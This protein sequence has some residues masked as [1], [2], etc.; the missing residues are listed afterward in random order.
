M[1]IN[2]RPEIDGLR[3]IAVF[4]VILYHANFILFDQDLFQG[5]FLG[6]DIFFVISGYLITSIILKEVTNSNQFSFK[7]FYVRRIRRI[8]PALFFVMFISLIAGYFLLLPNSFVDFGKSIASAVFFSSNIYFHFTRNGY[9]LDETFLKPLV[10][11]WS[12]SV[13]EQFYILFPIIFIIIFKFLKRYILLILSLGFLISLFLAEYYS[14]THASF[15]FYQLPARGFELLTGSLLAYFE[16]NEI[17]RN[18]KLKPILNKICPSLGITLIICAF[19]FFNFKTTFHPSFI[20]LIPVVGTGLIIWFSNKGELITDFLS[21]KFFVFFG[22]ISYSLYLWHYPIFA[23][24]RYIELFDNNILVKLCSVVITIIFSIFSYYLIE[25]PFRNKK[26]VSSKKLFLSIMTS[27]LILLI[28]SF[29]IIKSEGIK[30]RFP[31]IIGDK[32]ENEDGSLPYNYT[33][34]SKEKVLLLGDSH[35]GVLRYELNKEL[36]KKSY[37]S[38]AFKNCCGY[39]YL[40]NFNL[41]YKKTKDIDLDWAN[42]QKIIYSENNKNINDFLQKNE[43]LTVILYQQWSAHLLDSQY[44]D[45]KEE[46]NS[47]KYYFEPIS[48]FTEKNSDSK[49]N[50]SHEEKIINIKEGIKL[51]INNILKKEHRLIL[52][53][54]SP[55]MS[56]NPLLK[57]LKN[58]LSII[59]KLK[60]RGDNVEVSILSSSYDSYKKRNKMIFE[61]LDSIQ[62]PKIYRVYPHKFFCNT[63]IPDRCVTNSKNHSFYIDDHH[64]SRSGSKY[65]VEE[66][67]KVLDEIELVKNKN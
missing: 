27:A 23:F 61:I 28:S 48:N 50:L 44:S 36:K 7:N 67:I 54:P 4:A 18:H 56:F 66:I 11:T 58:H 49:L 19:I 53:Y 14:K 8:L 63:V 16:L 24:L 6:V 47:L 46:T 32:L 17:G 43:S 2:Y 25:K 38:Y 65:I 12:L 41:I 39:F 29:Y 3:A 33:G 62:D 37:S 22:L 55:E 42:K 64:L 13:E 1:K 59:S 40:Q 30:K 20:T 52:V 10:H 15:G 35:A 34:K 31:N 57:L 5:G 51:T 21:N 26:I 9:G 45:K 60:T